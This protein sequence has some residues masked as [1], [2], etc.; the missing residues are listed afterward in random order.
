LHQACNEADRWN[1]RLWSVV[2]QRDLA[3]LT[4]DQKLRAAA[5]DLAAGTQLEILL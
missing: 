5:R 2:C 1:L 3:A 4:K